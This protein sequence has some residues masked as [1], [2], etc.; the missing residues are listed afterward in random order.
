[1]RKENAGELAWQLFQ[2]T[3]NVTYYMLYKQLN[4]KK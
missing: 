1:M 3:G 4:G 2:R